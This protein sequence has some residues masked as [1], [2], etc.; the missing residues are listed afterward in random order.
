MTLERER[1]TFFLMM[2]QSCK[3]EEGSPSIYE[4]RWL[5]V[6]CVYV[7]RNVAALLLGLDGSL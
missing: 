3:L 2:S 6:L 7:L 5:V 1:E 4:E